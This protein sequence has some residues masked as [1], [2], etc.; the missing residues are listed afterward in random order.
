MKNVLLLFA[1]ATL[2]AFPACQS[3]E[4]ETQEEE[5]EEAFD[6]TSI[7]GTWEM[8]GN[9]PPDTNEVIAQDYRQVKIYTGEQVF[10]LAFD[11]DPDTVYMIGGGTYSINDSSFTEDLSYMTFHQEGEPTS[12]TFAHT[13]TEDSFG[14]SGVMENPAEDEE[15]FQLEERYKRAEVGMANSVGHPLVGVWEME[16]A[17]YGD[18]EELSGIPDSIRSLKVITPGHFYVVTYNKNDLTKV[19]VVF[20]S[21]QWTEGQIEETIIANTWDKG[22]NGAT[23][24]FAVE[25]DDNTYAQKGTM[26]YGDRDDYPLEEH[27][28]RIE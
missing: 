2:I 27:F 19:N 24:T 7:Q 26:T 9:M 22:M 3:G 18:E 23:F 12:Y 28:V 5:Q 20:G 11:T 6:P 10:F 14:Q 8:T 25:M 21:Q 1:L 13:I 17:M 15:D 16:Q 4:G